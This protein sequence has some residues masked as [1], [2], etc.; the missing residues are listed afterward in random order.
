MVAV[1]AVVGLLVAVW[2]VNAPTGSFPTGPGRGEAVDLPAAGR[3]APGLE[4][5]EEVATD[6]GTYRFSLVHA[7]DGSPVTYDAC[8]PLRLVV[9]PDGAPEG[10]EGLVEEAAAEIA[11]ATGLTVEIV[12]ETD[13][14]PLDGRPLVVDRYGSEWAP[15]LVAWSDPEETPRL[16]GDVAGM[17][18]SG[19]ARR[20][21]EVAYVS[22]SMTLDGPQFAERL[23]SG[24]RDRAR[25]VVLHELAH[26]VG[27]QHVSDPSALMYP[28]AQPYVTELQGGDLA[29]LSAL[30]QGGCTDW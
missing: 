17:A 16:A 2:Q 20:G 26:L 21:D 27:L 7:D 14:R 25:G 22:G 13:E 18:G 12:G 29:G 6:E 15:S 1:L 24:G 30:G 3:V 5:P 10:S 23:A 11:D 4:R 8:R 19:Y 28:Q 9:N